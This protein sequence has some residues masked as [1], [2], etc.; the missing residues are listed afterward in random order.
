[1]AQNINNK[2]ERVNQL[3]REIFISARGDISPHNAFVNSE[4]FIEYL[5]TRESKTKR[6][7]DRS[8]QDLLAKANKPKRGV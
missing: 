7:N 6:E 8:V 5:D 3:A 4:K 2:D 1:M